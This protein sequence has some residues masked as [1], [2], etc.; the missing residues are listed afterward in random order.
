MNQNSSMSNCELELSQEDLH[1]LN[2]FCI[3][4]AII[5]SLCIP[6]TIVLNALVLVGIYKSPSLHSPSNVLLCGLA[7]TDLGAG[8]IAMPVLVLE[9][10]SYVVDMPS[11]TCTITLIGKVIV[12]PFSGVSFVTITLVSLDRLLALQ[13]HMRYNQIVNNYRIASSVA[14]VWIAA[15]IIASSYFWCNDVLKWSSVIIFMT[16]LITCS[17]NNVVVFRILRRHQV[18]IQRQQQQV[19]SNS[20]ENDISID[21]AQKRRRSRSMLWVYILFLACYTPFL[22][23]RI[24]RNLKGKNTK[25]LFVSFEV[26]YHLMYLN[27]LLNPIFYCIKMESI[28]K[29]M[30]RSLPLKVRTFFQMVQH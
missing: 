13:F 24:L 7:L 10:I 16:C 23:T 26:T 3:V 8:A 9:Y 28:R 1:D 20:L 14:F 11:I 19:Q 18:D 30:F 21:M 2:A 4:Q 27:S 29:A 22:A 5:I 17:I 12:T 15:I 6:P 25:P